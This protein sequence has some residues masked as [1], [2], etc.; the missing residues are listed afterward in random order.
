MRLDDALRDQRI[1]VVK[2][3]V[4]GLGATA[5]RGAR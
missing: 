5:L 1:N 2:L 3:D 4:E